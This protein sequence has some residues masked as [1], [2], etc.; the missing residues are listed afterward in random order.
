MVSVPGAIRHQPNFA[1]IEPSLS[2]D[3]ESARITPSSWIGTTHS[4]PLPNASADEGSCPLGAAP[5]G[6]VTGQVAK[7]SK[8][9]SSVMVGV[10][11][12]VGL[13]VGC[14]RSAGNQRQREQQ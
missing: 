11:M 1:L 6:S 7:S 5:V 14:H 13:P 10:W 3:L 4:W 12:L 8:E 9:A 2:M